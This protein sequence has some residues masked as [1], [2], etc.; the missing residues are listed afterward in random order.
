MCCDRIS[1]SCG[2][3][4]RPQYQRVHRVQTLMP[5][6][7][8][9]TRSKG[10]APVEDVIA[11]KDASLGMDERKG[12]FT[13]GVAGKTSVWK[14][15]STEDTF[16]WHDALLSAISECA[17]SS[18]CTRGEPGHACSRCCLAAQ[19]S[20]ALCLL[21]PAKQDA[22]FTTPPLL[23]QCWPV[24]GERSL[25]CCKTAA[26]QERGAQAAGKA[27]RGTATAEHDVHR[28]ACRRPR[29]PRPRE[30]VW[31]LSGRQPRGG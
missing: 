22:P 18:L 16:K 1:G 6:K 4:H 2:A 3:I 13:V 12:F 14:G 29:A 26:V 15:L 19:A 25:R 21:G 20:C 17:L 31:W 8:V 11:L 10:N 27:R 30:H 23:M 9:I 7:M 24:F 28:R 5:H